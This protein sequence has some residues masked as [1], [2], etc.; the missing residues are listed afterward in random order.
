MRTLFL[1][2]L[3]VLPLQAQEVD[4]LIESLGADDWRVREDAARRLFDLGP[5]VRPTLE[6]ARGSAD[7]EVARLAGKIAVRID[8]FAVPEGYVQLREE[9]D[10]YVGV[11]ERLRR[12]GGLPCRTWPLVP[13]AIVAGVDAIEG[14]AI[15]LSIA[16][17][18]KPDPG[19]PFLV[20]REDRAIARVVYVGDGLARL[21][22]GW[23]FE[24]IATGDRAVD[25]RVPPAR[26][27]P[28]LDECRSVIEWYRA[29]HCDVR[30][31]TVP[32]PQAS[33]AGKVVAVHLGVGLVMLNLGESHGV[34]KGM[35]FVVRRAKDYV[36]L[37]VVE[38]VFPDMASA[39]IDT[40]FQKMEVRE[41][42][43]VTI[44]D[45]VE[46]PASAPT[47]VPLA[48][49]FIVDP[50]VLALISA[51]GESEWSVR[52]DA[53]ERLFELGPAVRPALVEAG[54]SGDPEIA[55]RASAIAS[56]I[57]E[58]LAVPDGYPRIREEA[59]SLSQ[60]MRR[61]G[62]SGL[63]S[64]AILADVRAVEGDL[65]RLEIEG[66][67]DVAPGMHF[68]VFREERCVGRVIHAGAG[69]ARVL[70]GWT[71]APLH[72]G[73]RAV[74]SADPP[75]RVADFLEASR[76]YVESLRR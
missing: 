11:L 35:S 26:V 3:A 18:S 7:P 72:P 56:S 52:E 51:L 4:R 9:L 13:R 34:E 50:D 19:P 37:V 33:L 27:V 53:A 49:A 69:L 75:G 73:D 40:R 12:A 41:G 16:F 38:E 31:R 25:A 71:P 58:A 63:S 21:V 28:A 24:P 74:D 6:V 45:R 62:W 61:S 23:T 42:D 2:A 70:P 64:R 20:L 55:G 10:E 67:A 5:S 36:G 76:S 17:G 60:P 39:R 68:L 46:G 57:D 47:P 8:E 44:G 32:D 48:S 1:L 65:V 43:D 30:L 15:G 66:G 54:R 29:S 59:D 22:P 14:A